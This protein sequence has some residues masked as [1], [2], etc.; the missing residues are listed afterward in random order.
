MTLGAAETRSARRRRVYAHLFFDLKGFMKTITSFVLV[1]TLAACD[2]PSSTVDGGSSGGFDVVVTGESFASEGYPFPPAAGAEL[3]FQDGWQLSYTNVVVFFDHVQI[4]ENPD[5]S[6]TDQSQTGDLVA[7]SSGPWVIDLAKAGPLESAEGNG[8]AWPVTTIAN[9]NKKGG[10]AFDTTQ[11]YAFGF[12]MIEGVAG[13]T[14]L[15][16]IDDALITQ[17]TTKGYSMLLVGVA[18]FK[19]TSCRSTVPSYDFERV[20]KRVNFSI[21]FKTPATFKNCINPELMPAES[22][23]IQSQRGVNTRAQV[24]FHL[25]HPFWEALKE[26]APL[27][28]DLVAAQKSVPEGQSAPTSVSVTQDDLV[29]VGFQAAKDAQGIALPWRTC[30]DPEP[31]DRTTGTVSYDTGGVPVTVPGG[32]PATGLRDLYDFM[33]Y[34]QSTLGHLNNDGLCFPLRNFDAP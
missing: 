18:E 28:F 29:G 7:E 26:D 12:E 6:A 24:T 27:R 3:A 33:S 13:A 34:N 1:F 31:T 8:T 15:N 20:P 9:Q 16:T 2:T 4:S 10:A 19:G 14:K 22:K 23:G 5:R 17:M 30:T 21:G 25:D 11:K 32:N